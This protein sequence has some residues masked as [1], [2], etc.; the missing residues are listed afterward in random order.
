[1]KH[2]RC[3]CVHPD[4]AECLRIRCGNP[5]NDAIDDEFDDDDECRC[6]CHR[7]EDDGLSMW[8]DEGRDFQELAR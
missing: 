3:A 5:S 2:P 4:A 8:D 6:S 7:E 1:V